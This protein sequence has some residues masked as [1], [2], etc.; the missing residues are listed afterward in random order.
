MASLV[1]ADALVLAVWHDIQPSFSVVHPASMSRDHVPVRWIEE[2]EAYRNQ[3]Q[4]EQ[5][6]KNV[7]DASD[8]TGDASDNANGIDGAESEAKAGFKETTDASVINGSQELARLQL[9]SFGDAGLEQDEISR[10]I[11]ASAAKLMPLSMVNW[12]ALQT[13]YERAACAQQC[14]SIF[15]SEAAVKK[16]LEH[17]YTS[18]FAPSREQQ[19]AVDNHAASATAGVIMGRDRQPVS[20]STRPRDLVAFS[21]RSSLAGDD[22]SM[23]VAA[24]VEFAMSLQM[25]DIVD[26]LDHSG[27]WNDGVVLEVFTE[28]GRYPKFVLV[29]LS[30]WSHEVVEWVGVAEG[31]LLPRGVAGGKMEFV[32]SRSQFRGK[33]LMLTRQIAHVLEQSFPQRRARL[34]AAAQREA[35]F[36]AHLMQLEDGKALQK[37]KRKRAA[38]TSTVV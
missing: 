31:R 9:P 1:I 3:L 8:S 24:S 38:N 29:R 36:R 22:A 30:L 20:L 28:G 26:A 18:M 16:S 6:E 19:P 25:G 32:L 11:D 35:K 33:K 10:A 4:K 34:A 17:L 15:D 23:A 37:R 14:A 7:D 2:A 5:E 12:R 27:C 21:S 13:I